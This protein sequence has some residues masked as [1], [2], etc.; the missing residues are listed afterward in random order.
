[1][2]SSKKKDKRKSKDDEKNKDKKRKKKLTLADKA[3][4]F[5]CYQKS[6]QSADHE[7]EFFDQAFHDEYRRKPNSLR[8]DFCG[9]FSVCC[10]LSLIHI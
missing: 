4:K 7:V 6:V 10:E 5:R 8:E 3:D 9:T 1:M 2:G